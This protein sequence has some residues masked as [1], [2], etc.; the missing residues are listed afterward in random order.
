MSAMH[1]SSSTRGRERLKLA[2]DLELPVL[3]AIDQHQ[4]LGGEPQQL[5]ADLRADAA[6]AAGHQHDAVVDPAADAVQ[7]QPHGFAP[8]QVFDLRR[9][10]AARPGCR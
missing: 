2:A 6:G 3:P 4:P 7:L 10:A 9:A 1:T 8:Q 5:P